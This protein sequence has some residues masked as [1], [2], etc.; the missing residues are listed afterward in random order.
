M[1]VGP[2]LWGILTAGP[3]ML[4]VLAILAIALIRQR[5]AAR[6]ARAQRRKA[7]SLSLPKWEPRVGHQ[8][9]PP[10]DDDP[11]VAFSQPDLNQP[12]DRLALDRSG[13]SSRLRMQLDAFGL[14][15]AQR[16]LQAPDLL[17]VAAIEA[18]T[19]SVIEGTVQEVLATAARRGL[20]VDPR[21]TPGLT[22]GL[23]LCAAQGLLLAEWHVLENG[24]AQTEP[25]QVRA[26]RF[27]ALSRLAEAMEKRLM[28]EIVTTFP[29]RD[30]AFQPFALTHF[31]LAAGFHRGLRLPPHYFAGIVALSA[32]A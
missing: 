9:L 15:L 14:G 5:P 1:G 4:V 7:D 8:E 31:A 24:R 32:A 11:L 27:F 21:G 3:V 23:S 16:V 18:D 12:A 6:R 29:H 20:Q 10:P 30:A 25:A 13:L 22:A 2:A 19:W 28:L 17:R 26:S